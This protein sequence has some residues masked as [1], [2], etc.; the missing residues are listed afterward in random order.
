MPSGN[1][2]LD[3]NFHF[4]LWVESPDV[5]A[6]RMDGL[7]RPAMWCGLDS[8]IIIQASLYDCYKEIEQIIGCHVDC[9]QNKTPLS[10][11]CDVPCTL[12]TPRTRCIHDHY[13]QRYWLETGWSS[14]DAEPSAKGFGRNSARFGNVSLF[15][16]TSATFD[17]I[18]TLALQ[19]FSSY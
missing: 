7:K 16:R 12:C 5:K 10:C 1:C 11:H 3:T 4:R 8:S 18:L 14:V 17:D 19:L 6:E 2:I 9:G 15:S 13:W